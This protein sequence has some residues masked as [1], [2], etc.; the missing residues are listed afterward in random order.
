[1]ERFVPVALL[2]AAG[3]WF[4]AVSLG[5]M[6][7]PFGLSHDGRNGAVWGLGTQAIRDLGPVVSRLGALRTDGTTYTNHPPMILIETALAETLAGEHP[8]VT[9][10]AA[11]IS[12]LVTIALLYRLARR[13]GIPALP[14]AAGVVVGIANPMVVAY[15]SMLDTP[16]TSLAA[17]AAVALGWLRAWQRDPWP[18]WACFAVA[19]F[20]CLSGWEATL[21]VVI[22]SAALAVR[23]LRATTTGPVRT[24]IRTTAIAFA[25]GGVVGLGLTVAWATWATG[26]PLAL[27]QPFLLRT[28]S[29][30]GVTWFGALIIQTAHLS[31]LFGVTL[32]GLAGCAL[33]LRVPDRRALAALLLGT[34]LLYPAVL[35][36]GAYY[37]DYWNYWLVIPIAMGAAQLLEWVAD[38]L[39]ARGAGEL[40]SAVAVV[41][42]PVVLMAWA[43]VPNRTTD[44][45]VAGTEAG[46]AVVDAAPPGDTE[47]SADVVG[48]YHPDDWM[49]YQSG[50]KRHERL[51]TPEDVR[52]LARTHPGAPVLVARDCLPGELGALCRTLYEHTDPAAE[53]PY[54]VVPAACLEGWLEGPRRPC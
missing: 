51:D 29:D 39:R 19:A 2:V 34:T 6:T 50:T 44:D 54:R 26:D 47:V 16:M 38:G 24:E 21:L 32:L 8:V 28:G 48:L 40:W 17:G 20:A 22:A 33:A 18:R 23:A 1:V 7:G 41:A 36:N 31:E 14:A 10:S 46:R 11:W 27:A 37:H 15:G 53:P 5:R 13:W 3:A 49:R 52:A 4:L 25:A 30:N 35:Y 12:L 42:V 9:R 45:I 43:T